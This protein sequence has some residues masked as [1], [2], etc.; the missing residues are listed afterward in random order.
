[1]IP[2]VVVIKIGGSTL[3]D[4]D[5]TLPDVV[6]LHQRGVPVVVV[7]GGGA[8]ITQWMQKQ[9]ARPTFVRGLRVTDAQSMEV[10]TAVLAGLVNKGLV[11]SLLGLGAKAVGLSGVDGGLLQA[12]ILDEA[13]GQ[14]G[15]VERVSTEPLEHLLE[16]GYLPVV[17]PIALY[18][19]DDPE[20]R[21]WLL[22]LN[23]DT[24]AGEIAAAMK[25]RHLVFLTDVEGVL[26]PSRRL[27]RRVTPRQIGQLLE[28]GVIQGG[29]A[30]K[31]EA[32]LRASQGGTHTR[33][34]DGRKPGA[35]IAAVDGKEEG[36]LVA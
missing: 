4:Q 8:L 28:G 35:L 2:G 17:A 24:A 23:G 5:S 22:N 33:I 16:K 31:V 36:T 30:P 19:G 6:A 20:K 21:G 15:K 11:A 29:M 18:C 34:V 25:A 27:I 12:S 26:D 3:G 7:H 9:G 13:L 1:M 10:V 32:A 14:V